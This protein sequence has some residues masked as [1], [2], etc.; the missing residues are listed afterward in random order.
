MAGSSSGITVPDVINLTGIGLLLVYG[1]F[2]FQYENA[3]D[4]ES[5][6]EARKKA[7]AVFMG[8]LFYSAVVATSRISGTWVGAIGVAVNAYFEQ[9]AQE[10][11]FTESPVEDTG[12]LGSIL[13]GV[14]TLGLVAY[15]LVTGLV[16][17]SLSIP[18]KVAR[19]IV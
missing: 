17:V 4:P 6:Q 11:V 18:V 13:S 5:E 1:Y 19:S 7:I 9:F 2:H 15:V 10:L 12:T 14:K 3:P 8:F 16:S